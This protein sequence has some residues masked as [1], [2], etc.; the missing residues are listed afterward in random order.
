MD[1]EKEKK[2]EYLFFLYLFLWYL[3][4]N[5]IIF[6]QRLFLKYPL[7][8]LKFF[9][10]V[11]PS[12]RFL[13]FSPLYL[14]LNGV[15]ASIY[16]E[17]YIIIP[18][19]QIFFGIVSLF[20]FFKGAKERVSSFSAYIITT[21]VSLYPSYL[22]YLNCIEP[23]A[24]IFSFLLIGMT[25]FLSGKSS[26]FSGTFFS[27]SFLL[28]PSLL[29]FSLIIFFFIKKNRI[30]YLIPLITS[31]LLLIFFSL[32]ATNSPTLTFM[33][34]GTV[35]Y[36]GNNPL[37]TGIA[38]TYP[39][40]I[41]LWE[42][43]FSGKEADFAHAL[44]RKVA[45]YE[46]GGKLS[47]FQNHFFWFNKSLNYIISYPL[48]W[49]KHF[50]K[51]VW[52][53]L[54]SYEA[55]DIFSLIIIF[56]KLGFF[57][58]ISFGIFSA[59]IFLAL[60]FKIKKIPFPITFCFLFNLMV[61]SLFYF[62]SRQRITLLPF[63]IFLAL[64]GVET[65]REN[66]KNILLFFAIY[67]ILFIKNMDIKN[68]E[69]TYEEVQKAGA[70]RIS[71]HNFLKEKKNFESSIALSASIAKAPYLSYS[72]SFAY[73]PFL[74]GTPYSQ[75]IKLHLAENYFN[76][77]LLYF[78]DG[79]I[80]NAL[81]FFEEIKFK[82]IERHYYDNNL[83]LYYYILCLIKEGRKEEGKN[84]LEIAK[85][86]YPARLSI[87]AIDYLINGKGDL[88]KYYDFLSINLILAETSLYLKNFE[89]S[90]KYS[91]EVIRIAPEMI[92][93]H[94]ISAVSLGYLEK[95]KEMTEEIKYIVSKKN[96]IVFHREWQELT[97]ILEKRYGGKRDFIPFLNSLRTLFPKPL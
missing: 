61:L 38:S 80:K 46:S 35:F 91:Q 68:Y 66:Q 71:S 92:Y 9:S 44:Y 13:D 36:E 54:S 21:L 56:N 19:L 75:A 83:P 60:S 20:I 27:L 97:E 59:L 12:E 7:N 30:Y 43:E 37:S 77:G 10:K 93:A 22:L 39:K 67:G 31:L 14:F 48:I 96:Q 4:Y 65:L 41:K 74:G 51:K 82:K 50:L 87:L 28:R 24:L 78:Y 72:H 76:Y 86:K 45:D 23:E 57:K 49:I 1:K 32:W 17:S 90:F 70:M 52:L 94:E 69:K 29:P 84:Y 64:Y 42:G 89:N 25:F 6:P 5:F 53:Y 8:A 26:L 18:Y 85:K 58:F 33:S 55:H 16:R 47:L 34:P 40:S 62:S 73:I 79:Q 3:V 2:L 95:Y 88:N 63:A 15:L 11:E 81:K